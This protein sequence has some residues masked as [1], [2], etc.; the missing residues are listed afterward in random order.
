MPWL[1]FSAALSYE[2][3][4]RNPLIYKELR[5]FLY[6]PKICVPSFQQYFPTQKII[7]DSG[8]FR[9]LV[10]KLGVFYKILFTLQ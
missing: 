4:N 9:E 5:L 8:T 2:K 10:S 7:L 3:A 1:L 6:V